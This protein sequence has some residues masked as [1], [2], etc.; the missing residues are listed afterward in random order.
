MVFLAGDAEP[1]AT[2]S[3]PSSRGLGR[4]PLKAV[5]PVRIRSGLHSACSAGGAT[6]LPLS[7]FL[8]CCG[9]TTPTP[10]GAGFARGGVGRRWGASGS[11]F[12]VGC[13]DPPR[14]PVWVSPAGVWGWRWRASF[15]SN[16]AATGWSQRCWPCSRGASCTGRTKRLLRVCRGTRP[17]AHELARGR[18]LRPA[19]ASVGGAAMVSQWAM[20]TPRA[21]RPVRKSCTPTAASRMPSSRESTS[22]TL[23]CV[24]PQ[25]RREYQ[26]T[27]RVDEG[28]ERECARD[29]P[30]VR[31]SCWRTA[32]P[33][34]AA[35]TASG[36]TTNGSSMARNPLL[37]GCDGSA[38]PSSAPSSGIALA[39]ASAGSKWTPSTS[40]TA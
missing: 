2:I 22:R 19:E 30:S 28:D 3:A 25:Q 33:P 24:R 14:P 4:R 10:P 15:F 21:V 27:E 9:G 11:R 31:P 20:W 38:S 7:R 37:S 34:G 35:A 1:P 32:T 8:V 12:S 40:P 5:T 6:R 26:S 16:C 23:S 13:G 36:L 17:E 29:E 39:G 18:L